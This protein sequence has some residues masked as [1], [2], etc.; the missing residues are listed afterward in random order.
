MGSLLQQLNDERMKSAKTHVV[1][2][3][4][5]PKVRP[6]IRNGSAKVTSWYS[7]S[8][9]AVMYVA[10]FGFLDASAWLTDPIAGCAATGV[11]LLV[12]GTLSG[13]DDE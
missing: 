7:R 12:L 4:R 5:K 8:Q 10:G 3:S 1:K 6:A 2:R 11:S 9:R 13:G